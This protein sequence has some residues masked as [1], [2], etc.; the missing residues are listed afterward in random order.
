M[1]F[2]RRAAAGRW[3]VAWALAALAVV[4]GGCVLLDRPEFGRDCTSNACSDAFV[5][6]DGRCVEAPAPGT[7]AGEQRVERLTGRVW[8]WI[9]AGSFQFG[10]E[11]QDA[12]CEDDERPGRT[13]HVAGFWMM[14][15]EVTLDAYEQC[16]AADVCVHGAGEQFNHPVHDVDWNDA[17]NFCAWVGGRLPTAVEWEYAAKSGSS[18]IYPW[19]DE[20]PDATRANCAS[21]G[22]GY[23]ST[24][25]VGSFPAGDTPWGLKDMAGNLWEWTASTYELDSREVRGGGWVGSTSSLRAG[26]RGR[27]APDSR[28]DDYG[29][30]CAQ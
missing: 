17:E 12:Q 20:A 2:A 19:G 16:K 3:A 18:R 26:N 8:I 4:V 21:C 30:R 14:R 27:G 1:T 15:T 6:V 22:D 23:G 24:A 28:N 10:C 9:P 11:P 5:C 13:E 25:P 7:D 29:F